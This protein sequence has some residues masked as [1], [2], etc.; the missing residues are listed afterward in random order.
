MYV[1]GVRR[2]KMKTVADVVEA[3]LGAYVSLGGEMAGLM[4]MDWLGIKVDFIAG[5]YD[6]CSLLN[7]TKFVNVGAIESL[8]RYSFRDRSLLVEALTHAS[9][10]L[11]EIP[12]CYQVIYFST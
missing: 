7:P 1:T 5:P 9:Y 10:M 4:L 3:L 2:V 12:K 11:P 6:S 8:L